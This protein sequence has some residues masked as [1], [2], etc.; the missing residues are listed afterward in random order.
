MT[1]F[2]IGLGDWRVAGDSSVFATATEAALA[3]RLRAE[4]F[5]GEADDLW[6]VTPEGARL[7]PY[8][9]EECGAIAPLAKLA[10]GPGY[11]MRVCAACAASI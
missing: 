2:R 4:A 11:G 1:G 9:C 7:D 5:P 10:Q 3:V 6:V 8:G